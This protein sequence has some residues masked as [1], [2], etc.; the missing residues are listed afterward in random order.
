MFLP[1]L[2]TIQ[3]VAQTD[4]SINLFDLKTV[5]LIALAIVIV[6][7]FAVSRKLLGIHRRLEALETAP[8]FQDAIPPKPVT[9]GIPPETVAAI[10]AAIHTTLRAHHRILSVGEVNPQRQA[11][12]AEGRRQVFSSHKVR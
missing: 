12:S 10:S 5:L 2:S 1:L 7:L 3:A 8:P 4:N 11:W 9:R 6:A